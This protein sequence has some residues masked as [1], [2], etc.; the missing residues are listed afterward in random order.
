MLRFLASASPVTRFSM[1]VQRLWARISSGEMKISHDGYL[2]K[3]QLM[4]SDRA[5]SAAVAV[6]KSFDTIVLDEA[7]DCTDA[8][9]DIFGGLTGLSPVA[10]T[11]TPFFSC[12][13]E[14]YHCYERHEYHCYETVFSFWPPGPAWDDV[15]PFA[16]YSLLIASPKSAGWG[17][18]GNTFGCCQ[19]FKFPIPA[20]QISSSSA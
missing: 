10:L 1:H 20:A 2:K 13:R 7:Q 16:R 6:L 19:L 3:F 15:T 11:W 5:S 8:M 12:L 17:P 14:Q 18:P 4:L 9:L